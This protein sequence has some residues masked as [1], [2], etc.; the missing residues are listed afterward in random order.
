MNFLPTFLRFKRLSGSARLIL[1]A[2]ISV[3]SVFA[4]GEID[5]TF[6]AAVQ[7]SAQGYVLTVVQQTDGKLLVG[8]NFSVAGNVGRSNVARLNLDGTVDTTFTPPD[9]YRQLG[10]SGGVSLRDINIYALA[11]Q[12]DGKIIVG[13]EFY[14]VGN[15]I[16]PAL[17]RL[18]PDGSL[19]NFAT[20]P[21]TGG[22]PAVYDI[23]IQPDSKILVSGSFGI[24][25]YNVDGTRDT[26]FNGQFGSVRSFALQPDG[27]IVY[28]N[29]GNF[30]GNLRRANSDGSNDSSFLESTLNSVSN[31]PVYVYKIAVQADGKIL[32][33]GSFSTN[34]TLLRNL[35]RLNANGAIDPDFNVNGNGASSDV[36]SLGILSDG[37]IVIGGNFTFYNNTPRVKNARLNPNGTLDTTFNY[38]LANASVI[39]AVAVLNDGGF[40]LGGVADVTQVQ[41]GDK[42]VKFNAGGVQ[43]T[44]FQSAI[45][46]RGFVF[47]VAAQADGKILLGGV[48][49]RANGAERQ[50]VA[51]LNQDGSTD[52]GFV[53]NVAGRV[54]AVAAQPDGKVLVG[55]GAIT[56]VNGTARI[57][58]A[59]LN[60]DGTLDT[61]FQ[62]TLASG[63]VVQRIVVLPGGKILIAGNFRLSNY[64]FVLN[65]ARLNADGSTDTTFVQSPVNNPGLVYALKVQAD[66]KI[67]VGG[68]FTQIG[69]ANR[70]RLARFNADGSLDA[71]FTTP[72]GAN[73]TIYD[74]AIQ[75]NGNIVIGGAFLAVNGGNNGTRPYVARL[76]PDGAT[77]TNFLAAAN[78]IVFAVERQADEKILLGGAFSQINGGARFGIAR[79]NANGTFDN[80]FV[81]PGT[82]D[83]VHSIA[84]QTDNRIL[85]GGEFTRVNNRT[86]TVSVARLLNAPSV[87]RTPF[88][89]DADGKADLSLFRP[90]NGTWYILP[91]QTNGFYGFPFGQN[92][93]QIAPADYD[94]DGKTDVAVFRE[95]V[96]GAGDQAY[97]YILNSADN[98]F[99]AV[100]FGT[101]GD[102][103]TVGDWDGDGRAD[104]AVYRAGAT[105]GA[106]SNFYY[107][108]SSQ[109]NVNFLTV[110]LGFAGDKPLLGDFDG[111]GKIDAAVFRPSSA[112]F[113]II[114]SSSGGFTGVN[115]GVSTDIPVP[116][117]YDGD[118]VTNIAVF[119]PSNGFWYTSTNPQTNFGAIQFGAAGDLPVPAD[120]D[121]DGKA[122][123]AV[124]RPS[125]GAW[126]LN[127]STSG[128]IGVQ[129]GAS[130]DKPAPNA[131]IR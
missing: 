52:A 40:I 47:Q 80:S 75:T 81:G 8:G 26:T 105:A 122:D 124:F 62:T 100:G 54:D 14:Q 119:R 113:E 128:F 24:L 87:S 31:T 102:Q 112:R 79:L 6:N 72:G 27:K 71:T 70:T 19:D 121:G 131:Y 129:F 21:T 64:N 106:R 49:R 51:R 116:A 82:N 91:S 44:T 55:G 34:G 5:P 103:P 111:D 35:I 117:D 36:R 1:A 59:R 88:D 57:A 63:A 41:P 25:R 22:Q 90:S 3:A 65:L 9:F 95:T 108:P 123:V 92:G 118:G 33:G 86:N 84:L 120:Y 18:N 11:Q 29:S 53:A 98:T 46:Q 58:A 17:V 23:K 96:A 115:F 107:R 60:A 50:N 12:S 10:G 104:L 114:N 99:R 7:D 2:L 94:G 4:A 56:Q 43:D 97:F 32:V 28:G 126:F 16:R 13:G 61:T 73:N 127:R 37:K 67:V 48:F 15:L 78:N 83:I 74:L 101:Q 45:Y 68:E 85:L 69:G 42:L 38:N 39:Y 66:G 89:F 93:D 20:L 77:D 110:L 125:N 109:P 130:G 76:L 30:I